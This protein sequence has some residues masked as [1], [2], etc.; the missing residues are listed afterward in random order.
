MEGSHDD[1]NSDDN[2]NDTQN[3]TLENRNKRK[4]NARVRI[5]HTTEEEQIIQQ[6][7]KK[8]KQVKRA[9]LNCRLAHSACG[10][11]RPCKRCIQYGIQ[12]SCIDV[13]RRNSRSQKGI[14]NGG[15][16]AGD[17]LSSSSLVSSTAN[18]NNVL[19][20]TQQQQNSQADFH[21]LSSDQYIP[22]LSTL[23][24]QH[25]S[26]INTVQQLQSV[27][28]Q[29]QQ[30][31]QQ[32]RMQQQNNHYNISGSSPNSSFDSQYRK[33][34]AFP[35]FMS[36]CSPPN[37]VTM[38]GRQVLENNAAGNK[39]YLPSNYY[40]QHPNL[41]NHSY[42]EQQ[43]S[44]T[45]LETMNKNQSFTP[46]PIGDILPISLNSNHQ[47]SNSKST[48]L[49]SI[50]SHHS[51][52][53]SSLSPSPDPIDWIREQTP[54]SIL[55]STVSSA[56]QN[57]SKADSNDSDEEEVVR[58][59]TNVELPDFQFNL[60]DDYFSRVFDLENHSGSSS[61]I[62]NNNSTSE[63]KEKTSSDTVQSSSQL[64]KQDPV[65]GFVF[66]NRTRMTNSNL[67]SDIKTP[68]SAFLLNTTTK[69]KSIMCIA[70]W[71]MDGSLYSASDNFLKWFNVSPSQQ[72][73]KM[74]NLN[75][76]TMLSNGEV[77][78]ECDSY[79]NLLHFSQIFHP[80]NENSGSQL[81][82]KQVLSGKSN[83]F[84]GR[85]KLCPLRLTE[86]RIN[87]IDQGNEVETDLSTVHQEISQ[88]LIDC[89]VSCYRV[90]NHMEKFY[91]VS[92]MLIEYE[93]VM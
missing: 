31:Q 59:M 15:N 75:D 34:Q 41:S 93:E 16:L 61:D 42:F 17:I 22:L 66:Q 38:Q 82:I 86:K 53:S 54:T 26:L 21:L 89:Y 46:N 47:S 29:M 88:Q 14:A 4:K 55:P 92:H 76:I 90:E 24:A 27:N 83:Y 37:H 67:S 18:Q 12:D 70:V 20:L 74:A 78:V 6:P 49:N 44:A 68:S 91:T 32:Q 13:S 64:S 35:N 36:Q 84:S 81:E 40:N 1:K 52:L 8:R 60:I 62:Y 79:S 10:D 48:L 43:R 3:N 7:K 56:S 72:L 73:V 25:Q 45:M 50:N 57:T 58:F 71:R 30:Q 2:K 28:Q 19:R 80:C 77:N 87:T 9:C 5:G 33:Q 63:T 65:D 39:N 85:A 23:V 51:H 11:T 69:T